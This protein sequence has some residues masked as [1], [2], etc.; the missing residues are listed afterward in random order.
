[1]PWG[2]TSVGAAAVGSTFGATDSVAGCVGALSGAAVAS[3][4]AGFDGALPPA[5]STQ[6]IQ[7]LPCAFCSPETVYAVFLSISEPQTEHVRTA[8]TLFNE[9]PNAS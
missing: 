6:L 1:M 8:D 4:A 5:A 3:G 7:R 9:S 2:A